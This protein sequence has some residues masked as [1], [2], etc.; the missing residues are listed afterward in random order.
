MSYSAKELSR[1]SGAPYELYRFSRSSQEWR[2][3]SSESIIAHNSQDYN[4]DIISRNDIQQNGEEQ[5]SSVEVTVRRDNAFAEQFIG[6]SAPGPVSLTIF[7]NHTGEVDG[8]TQTIFIG[9]VSSVEI[10]GSEVT[11]LCTS[12]ESAFSNPTNRVHAQ[13]TCP[14]MLYDTQCGVP[15]LQFTFPGVVNSVSTDGRDITVVEAVNIP[16]SG[17]VTY[18]QN[19]IIRVGDQFR[20][21]VRQTIGGALRLFTAFNP[22]LI[23][24]EACFLSAGCDRVLNTCRARFNNINRFGGFPFMPMRSPWDR[25]I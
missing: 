7:R 8:E 5:S 3:T 1:T 18:Y 6:A 12:L 15:Q 19:G 9:Q 13:R 24:G 14:W 11:V 10:V 20:F 17:D 16:G 4:P 23:G 21:I 25:L 22:P 2:F